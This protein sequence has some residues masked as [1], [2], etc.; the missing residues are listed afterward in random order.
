MSYLNV[1]ATGLSS[2]ADWAGLS[3]L[4]TIVIFLAVCLIIFLLSK[5]FRQFCIGSV[6]VGVSLGIYRFSRWIGVETAVKHNYL[7]IRWFCYVTGFIVIAIIIGR[8][9]EKTRF[10]KNLEKA[11]KEK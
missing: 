6:I 7:P 2:M 3:W 4:V 9:V 10:M 5:N 8:L 11:I 1:T